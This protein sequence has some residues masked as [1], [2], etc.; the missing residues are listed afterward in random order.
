MNQSIDRSSLKNIISDSIDRILDYKYVRDIYNSENINILSF[1]TNLPNINLLLAEVMEIDNSYDYEEV[2]YKNLSLISKYSSKCFGGI[3]SFYGLTHMGYGA[4]IGKE[5][6]KINNEHL[7]PFNKIINEYIPRHLNNMSKYKLKEFECIR[8]LSGVGRYLI[9]FLDDKDSLT[10]IK[11]ILKNTIEFV[12]YKK[13]FNGVELPSFYVPR[14]ELHESA[15]LE[16]SMGRIDLGVSHGISGILSFLSLAYINGIEVD[17]QKESIEYICKYLY[18]YKNVNGGLLY[19]PGAIT[20]EDYISNRINYDYGRP[21]WCYGSAGISRALYLAGTSIDN[22]EYINDSVKSI[23]ENSKLSGE[24]NFFISPTF[25]HGYSGLIHIV[26]LFKEEIN[27]DEYNVI[28]KNILNKILSFMN[29]QAKFMFNEF[30]KYDNSKVIDI[31]NMSIA[32]GITAILLPLV[33]LIKKS[34]Y[35]WDGIFLIN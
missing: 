29:P 27:N 7:K 5:S 11:L 19:W 33:S 35:S 13:S 16:Y 25:C 28:Q 8:G 15:V 14:E 23:I 20:F 34:K 24:N 22:K 18:K 26:N 4:M 21:S 30:D 31:N 17:G 32:E 2:I 12:N 1:I 6:E 10:N 3:S 9:N